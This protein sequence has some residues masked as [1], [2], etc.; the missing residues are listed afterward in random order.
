VLRWEGGFRVPTR[1]RW[2]GVIKPGAVYSEF[3]AHEDL[4]PT[5]RATA[6]NPD[7][8]AQ[9]GKGYQGGDRTSKVHLHRP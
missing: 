3:F 6:G 7:V 9:C 1:I 2:P 4:I 8:V 5:L